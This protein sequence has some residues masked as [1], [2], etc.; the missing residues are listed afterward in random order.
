MR[1]RRRVD[2][3]LAQEATGSGWYYRPLPPESTWPKCSACGA[4]ARILDA[5]NNECIKCRVER[6][7]EARLA[8]RAGVREN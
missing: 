6:M 4:R 2:P 3:E 5:E 7:K 1:R 8:G